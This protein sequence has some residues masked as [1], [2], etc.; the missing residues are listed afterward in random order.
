MTD[1]NYCGEKSV[2]ISS[3]LSGSLDTPKQGAQRG[4][5]HLR[6]FKPSK[7][8]KSLQNIAVGLSQPDRG[9]FQ[10]Q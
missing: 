1:E 6:L 8:D 5:D 2:R 3:L 7:L 9:L 10:L 4:S